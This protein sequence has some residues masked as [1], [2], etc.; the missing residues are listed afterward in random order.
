M[1]IW[2]D[3]TGGRP[4]R[5][6]ACAAS[7]L[8]GCG[9]LVL[10]DAASSQSLYSNQS[11]TDDTS[12]SDTLPGN[13]AT[14]G[15]SSTGSATSTKT[16]KAATQST[17]DDSNAP[18]NP[19]L[20]LDGTDAQTTGSILDDDLRRLNARETTVDNLNAKQHPDRDDAQGIP[21]GTFTLRPSVNQSINYEKQT[22]GS[23]DDEDR[24]YLQTDLNGT[25]TSDWD[26]HSLTIK[27]DGVWQKNISGTGEEKPTVD[28]NADLRLD[29]PSDTTAHVTAGYQFFREDTDDPNAIANASKQSA[30]N[31]FD[32]G[33]SI[34][35]DFGLLRG[36]TA[37]ALTRTIYSNATLSDGTEVNLSDRN[38]TAG[39]WR[40]RIGYELS[41]A[42]IPFIEAD[43]GRT[44]Y[45]QHLDSDGYARS[46]HGYGGKVGVEVDLGEKLK[47]ELGIGYQRTEF[48]DSR[49][50]AIDSPTIDGNIAWSPQRGTDVNIGFSTTV[51]PSTAAGDSGYVAYQLTNTINHQLR[52]NLTGKLTGGITWRDYPS[53]STFDDETVYD[54]GTGLAWGINRY[55]DLTGDLGYELTS[56]KTGDDT[57]QFIAGIGIAAKR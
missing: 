4:F 7:A 18:L 33:F 40:G 53:N 51:E 35:R 49:L 13:T 1:G 30:V 39:T 55:F 17:S 16:S 44:L 27:G 19:R 45:D 48:E 26:R 43:L 8:L 31:Q 5:L 9:I 14:G 56:R 50:E 25:L 47:G 12:L 34:E 42:I 54:I 41:P 15:S 37:V 28:I 2:N 29:L 6:T 11:A 46:N 36:T 38:Q 20:R 57:Q 21:I 32:G 22:T 24:S 23:V 10:P 52:D 3:R